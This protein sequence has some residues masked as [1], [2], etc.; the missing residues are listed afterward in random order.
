MAAQRYSDSAELLVK[1]AD[2]C[3]LLEIFAAGH[4]DIATSPD[5]SVSGSIKDSE[6]R[7]L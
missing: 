4:L 6:A 1:E 2:C 3:A 5:L 7:M